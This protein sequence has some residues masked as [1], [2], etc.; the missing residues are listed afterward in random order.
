[1]QLLEVG[2]PL[3]VIANQLNQHIVTT[4]QPEKEAK[5]GQPKLESQ[6][7]CFESAWI[8]IRFASWISNHRTS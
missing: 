8:R 1:M 4:G 2:V 7:Q 3:L 5:T 6:N